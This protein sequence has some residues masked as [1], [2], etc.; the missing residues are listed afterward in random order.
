MKESWYIKEC[1]KV[2]TDRDYVILENSEVKR[3]LDDILIKSYWP[4]IQNYCNKTKYILPFEKNK[5]TD[6]ELSYDYTRSLSFML[7]DERIPFFRGKVC[8]SLETWL[9]GSEFFLGLPKETEPDIIFKILGNTRFVGNPPKLHIYKDHPSY[10]QITFNNG[11]G[12]SWVGTEE[13]EVTEKIIQTI[14]VNIMLYEFVKH[15]MVNRDNIGEF[16]TKA[17]KIY[18]CY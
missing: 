1:R 7:F 6:F 17:Y 12:K 4:H 8:V 11:S 5:E 14:D 18:E 13:N 2:T 9:L 16:I 3:K 15:K 10:F